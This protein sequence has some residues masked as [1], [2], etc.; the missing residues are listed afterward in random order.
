MARAH[1]FSKLSNMMA[2][3]RNT[4]E[5]IVR[6]VGCTSPPVVGAIV[7]WLSRI[8]HGGGSVIVK[9]NGVVQVEVWTCEL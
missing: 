1:T 9:L 3:R 7:V 8:G 4:Q 2:R 5:R 6:L